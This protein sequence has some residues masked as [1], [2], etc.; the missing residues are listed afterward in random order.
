LFDPRGPV[1]ARA[2]S[3]EYAGRDVVTGWHHHD[4]HQLEYASH[5]VV[6]VET[7]AGRY[8]LPP[9]RAAWIPAGLSH[10][11]TLRGLRSI[12][13][14]LAP[15]MVQDA[16]PGVRVLTAVP[17]LRE[18][19]LYARRWPVERAPGDPTAEVYFAALAALC[20]D[21]ITPG[22]RFHLP[23]SRDPVVA[24]AMAHTGTH[25]AEATMDSAAAAAGVSARTLRRLFGAHVGMTWQQYR[26]DRRMLHAMVLL[27]NHRESSVLSVATGCGFDSVS[28]FTRAFRL[29]TG[30]TPGAYRR[31]FSPAT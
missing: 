5:G 19:L 2:G 16:R 28:A 11:S 24:A 20:A 25:L 9:Q 8:V 21:W 26:S 18:L 15:D 14:F 3:Y 22:S 6:E 10:R 4:M 1:P 30:E 29:Y 27:E 7:V 31:H 12:S 13:V 17:V 23:V